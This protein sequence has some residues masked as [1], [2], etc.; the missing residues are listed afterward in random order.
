MSEKD[1]NIVLGEEGLQNELLE[2]R[3]SKAKPEELKQ[4]IRNSVKRRRRNGSII[5]MLGVLVLISVAFAVAF[6][7]S[8]WQIYNTNQELWDAAKSNSIRVGVEMC[9][10]YGGYVNGKFRTDGIEVTC[11]DKSFIIDGEVE[12]E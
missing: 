9:Q 4:I 6:G 12:L 3:M 5:S 7:I 8:Y 10:D 1:Y 11:E 2:Q